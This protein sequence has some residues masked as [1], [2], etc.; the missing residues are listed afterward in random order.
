[1]TPPPGGELTTMQNSNATPR[2]DDAS[3]WYTAT[4]AVRPPL[5][6]DLDVDVCV[7]GGGLAGLTIS[8][9]VA[10]RGWSVA[11]IEAKRLAWN[12]SGRNCGF[13]LP[14]FAVAAERIVERVGLDHARALWKLSEAG[15]DYV[16]ATIRETGMPGVA[17]VDG[18]LDVSKIDNSDEVVAEIALLGQE[19]GADIEGWST[20][21]VRRVLK[22]DRYFHAIHF[23]KAFHINPLRY[24]LGLADAAEAA[25]ARI[26]EE[27]PAVAIDPAGLRKR[28][29][30]PSAR[31]RAA[32]I[33]LA[34]NAHLGSLLPYLSAMVLP[35]TSYVAVTEPLG[36]RL[37]EA[38][39]YMGAVSDS[40]LAGYHFRVVAGDRL[41]WA[42]GASATPRDPAR[43]TRSF[44]RAIADTFP[45][46]G[47]VDIAHAWSGV[48][49]F[50]VHGMPQVGEVAPGLWIASA[51]GS[52]GL[53][54]T[55]MAGELIARAI[56]E[57]DD[58]WRLF[59]PYELVWAGG[60]IGRTVARIDRWV[61]QKR[62]NFAAAMA[63]RREAAHRRAVTEEEA[64]A[65]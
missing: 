38:I 7:V 64:T 10:R 30:T 42:G 43:M 17:P 53:N 20:E 32:H 50:A 16:R 8:R 26:F 44:S 35:V 21:R 23:P 27:T 61:R 57:G 34:G 47:K 51:F 15:A 6:I 25:G 24:A 54:T 31:V 49:G 59:L 48:V 41:M 2:G 55:A 5:A 63:H 45:Q 22:T 9:E 37:A 14:G 13:V 60:R 19:F 58:L 11:L 4:A 65:R 12:A 3:V 33:V 39:S 1:M 36:G 29:M 52:H 46:L 62:E 28:I 18:W 40:R 56:V